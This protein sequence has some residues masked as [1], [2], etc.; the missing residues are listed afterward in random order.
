MRRSRL[1]EGGNFFPEV[2]T[3]AGLVLLTPVFSCIGPFA[4][5]LMLP[6]NWRLLAFVMPVLGMACLA[7]ALV[8]FSG[9][10]RPR[11]N[12]HECPSC[13]YDL[14]GVEADHCPE[15]GSPR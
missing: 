4:I 2:A 6:G 10:S 9:R 5:V 3:A 11:H 13:G 14:T 1:L 15:C 8:S 7:G 12:M